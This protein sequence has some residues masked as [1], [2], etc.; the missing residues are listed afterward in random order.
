MCPIFERYEREYQKNLDKLEINQEM[1]TD[2]IFYVDHKKAVK[3]YQRSDAGKEQPLPCD[4]RPP[5]ILKKTLNY[6]ID[7]IIMKHGIENTHG[8]VRDRTRSIRQDFSLQNIRD[9]SAVDAHERIARYHILCL[10]Q[11]CEK[12]GFSVQQEKEQ[13][14]KVLQSLQEF[15]DEGKEKSI[16]Y[17]N[18]AEFRAYYIISHIFDNEIV[19]KAELYP[20][21]ILFH[22]YVQL[23]LEFQSLTDEGIYSRLFKKVFSPETPYLMGCLMEIHFNIIRKKALIAMN[24]AIKYKDNRLPPYPAEK[25]KNLLGFDTLE[26]L[27]DFIK[28]YG[29]DMESNEDYYGVF[30]DKKKEII[31]PEISLTQKRTEQL[32]R[33]R[34]NISYKE[35]INNGVINDDIDETQPMFSFNQDIY[36]S[37]NMDSM[38]DSNM[39]DVNMEI[40]EPSNQNSSMFPVFNNPNVNVFNKGNDSSLKNTTFSFKTG[41][42]INPPKKETP[43]FTF[44]SS[45]KNTISTNNNTS[46]PK[47]TFTFGSIKTANVDNKS[48][49]NNNNNKSG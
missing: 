28:Y 18:E 29:I 43:T 26:D 39:D 48:V 7:E 4:V 13:L 5:P 16:I 40:K 47:P 46:N 42:E 45:D 36:N 32:E 44:S 37:N 33:K 17:P 14:F 19:R 20:K 1:S 23:A 34:D 12:E 8:F 6:L 3:R 30:F 21:E 49:D 11:L 38:E 15:Y 27:I 9:K 22:P 41:S 24:S 25:L 31:E 2:E 10:H 35:I